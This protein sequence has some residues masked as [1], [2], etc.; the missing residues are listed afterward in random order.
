M[1]KCRC[2][3]VLLVFAVSPEALDCIRPELVPSVTVTLTVLDY[4]LLPEGAVS[5][6]ISGDVGE[7]AAVQT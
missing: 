5:E 7:T 1:S 3:C 6:S 4:V 2:R